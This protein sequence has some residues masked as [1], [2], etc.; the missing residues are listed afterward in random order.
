MT[1]RAHA[2]QR[3]GGGDSLR[4]NALLRQALSVAERA[5][6]TS[7]LVRRKLAIL[8]GVGVTAVILC[9]AGVWLVVSA[10]ADSNE[11]AEFLGAAIILSSGLLLVVVMT[12]ALTVLWGAYVYA[13]VQKLEVRSELEE[14]LAQL[15]A[16][17][18][19]VGELL[20]QPTFAP[21]VMSLI[22]NQVRASG[23]LRPDDVQATVARR[24]TPSVI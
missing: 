23:A 19:A 10:N 4:S 20:Q 21:T 1:S 5:R 24:E 13:H 14:I 15:E 18:K 8:G 16:M 6:V 9:V 11:R 2:R 12:S 22:T 17:T 3:Y 7:R